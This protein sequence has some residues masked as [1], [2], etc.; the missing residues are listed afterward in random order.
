MQESKDN[1]LKFAFEQCPKAH[2]V[3]ADELKYHQTCWNKIIVQR[4]PEVKHNTTGNTLDLHS[5]NTSLFHLMSSRLILHHCK[6][7]PTPYFHCPFMIRHSTSLLVAPFM[8][9]VFSKSLSVTL[10]EVLI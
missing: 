4:V 7:Y 2:G 3:M 9:Q 1:E 10:W 5:P 6:N 8:T